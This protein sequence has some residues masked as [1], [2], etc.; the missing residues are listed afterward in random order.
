MGSGGGVLS[1]SIHGTVGT[2]STQDRNSALVAPA[3]ADEFNVI[4]IDLIPVAC[5]SLNDILFQFDSSF[6]TPDARKIL[7]Q[8][9]A[10]RKRLANR[11]GDQPPLSVFGHADPVGDDEYNKTLSG[12]RAQAVFGL[13][14]NDAGIWQH[15]F[16]SPFKGDDWKAKGVLGQMQAALGEGPGR[17][18][19][20]VI[21]DYLAFVCPNP[22]TPAD[23]LGQGTDTGGKAALQGCSEFNLLKILSK[24]ENKTFS[25]STR[26]SENLP[27]RRVVVFLFRPGTIVNPALWP[28]PRSTEGTA[29]CRLRFFP[30]AKQRL[31]PGDIRREHKE[32]QPNVDD[33]TVA[34]DTFACRF[35]DR[36]AH[37]SPCEKLLRTYQLRLFDR[38]ARPLPFAPH[39][40]THEGAPQPGRT[41]DDAVVT[42]HDLIVPARVTV[43]WSPAQ[44]GDDQNSPPPDPGAK[45]DFQLDIT[46]DIPAAQND[47][48]TALERLNN[49]GYMSDGSVTE[50]DIAQF[51]SDYAD[52]LPPTVVPG[53][54]DDDTKSVLQDVY[55]TANPLVKKSEV[56]SEADATGQP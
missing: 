11:K 53:K 8:L 52:Q 9:P 54:L 17:P 35:Y 48:A 28:C 25:K 1:G 24:S 46:V 10:L 2:H 39:V 51:Q 56:Q 5:L 3:T 37:T 26:D 19:S 40:V 20:A 34:L 30:D 6:V 14:T 45:F 29:G 16:D 7:S 50:D 33:P 42:I 41:G 21:P 22:V 38:A 44:P 43:Q 13:L 36:V 32:P 31:A 18:A 23:F 4:G 27:N 49:L 55:N 12:R 47:D 15:L